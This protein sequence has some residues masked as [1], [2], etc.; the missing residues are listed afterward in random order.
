MIL[1]LKN[2]SKHAI[3]NKEDNKNWFH[4]YETCHWNT[5]PVVERPIV[6]N[7]RPVVER[8]IVR[9]TRFVVERPIVRNMRPVVERPIVQNTRLV[10]ERLIVQN[11]VSLLESFQS[12]WSTDFREKLLS[13][14]A[15]QSILKWLFYSRDKTVEIYTGLT[16]Q[17][18]IT[19]RVLC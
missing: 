11:T 8:P 17:N 1:T 14:N 15:N 2:K 18:S 7:M 5:G 10:I 9:N 4:V 19:L 6:R 12:T 13:T 16:L 3:Y